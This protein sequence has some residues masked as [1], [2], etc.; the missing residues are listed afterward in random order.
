MRRWLALLLLPLLAVPLT[1]APE[2]ESRPH[3]VVLCAETEYKTD[4]TLPPFAKAQLEKDFRVTFVFAD[5]K[6]P[7]RL[8]GLEVLDK[9]DVLFLS[10]RRKPLVEAD[11]ARIK[12]FVASG[13]PVVAIRTSSHAFAARP[14]DKVPE[15]VA[16]WTSFDKDILGGNY[17]NH[18]P[19][20]MKTKVQVIPGT[21]HPILT[22]IRTDA[23]PVGS[24]LYKTSPLAAGAIPLLAG[25]VEGEPVEPVAWV[26][27]RPGGG[28]VFYMSLGHVEDFKEPAVVTLLRNGT[29]WAAGLDVPEK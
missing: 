28:R 27:E 6:E 14:G 22:G 11:L 25:T 3:L 29:Y 23:F 5:P 19:E 7:T 20:S 18:Y 26:R 15:G 12:K 4:T 21:K 8:P 16:E 13:K 24:S 1:A 9:A 10:V 2:K 17:H